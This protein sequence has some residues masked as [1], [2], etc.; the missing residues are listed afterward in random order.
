M[1]A[2]SFPPTAGASEW[3]F[4]AS[5]FVFDP[6]AGDAFVSPIGSAERGTL[7]FEARWNYE[8]LHSGSLFV[9]RRF[10]FGGDVEGSVTPI[11]GLV[12]GS[13][14]GF[15]PGV[16]LEIG[17]RRLALSTESEWIVDFHDAGDNFLYSWLEGTVAVAGGLRVGVAGQRMKQVETALAMQRG[18][19][20]Q[21]ERN[22]GWLAGYWFNPDRSE[23]ETF[24]FA[25][26]WSF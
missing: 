11:A 18:P 16:E 14:D 15:V 7:H 2:G 23:D 10:T 4:D 22:R 8:D 9:G 1:I 26:G 6:P 21:L 25:G 20:V 13:T 24:V 17:W 12:A 19:M 3:T 5:A